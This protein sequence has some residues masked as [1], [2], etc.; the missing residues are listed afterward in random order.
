MPTSRREFL[1]WSSAYTAGFLGVQRL[2]AGD[3]IS[4]G[5]APNRGAGIGYGPLASDP[6]G[7]LDLP[8]G[9]RYQVISRTGDEMADGLLVPGKPDGMATFPGPDGLTLILRNHEN[10]P[11]DVGPFG[12]KNQRLSRIDK[13]LLYD[14]GEEK[15]PGYG[16]VS[17]VVYDT[18]QQ[19]VVK[20]FLS[21]GG[22]IRNCAGGPTPWGSW[23]TCEETTARKGDGVL[24]QYT[25][26]Q[27]HGYA[28]E[29]KAGAQ[30]GLQK[31]TPLRDMGRFYREAVAV[32][33]VT[34]IVYQTEDL[35]D[36]LLYRFVPKQ[37]GNLA[38]GGRLQALAVR[39]KKSLDTRNYDRQRV[40]VGDRLS[41]AWIDMHDVDAP[42][43][44][45]R[46]Q[47]FNAG[48]ARFGR[49]EGMW[50]SDGQIYFA[51]TEGGKKNIGQI[52]R[53]EPSAEGDTLEL[54]AEPND[55]RMVQNAD[56][57]TMSPWGD[58]VVCEDRQ[59]TTVRLVGVTPRGEFYT[60]ADN[61]AK[62]EFAG[63]C[64]SP[65][66]STLFVNIQPKGLTLAIT[67]PWHSATV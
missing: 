35:K 67:G 4:A 47:G 49:G 30:P 19:K 9:F 13:A 2:I 59:G 63:A 8:V 28:F 24:R 50:F 54:F 32:D 25:C 66:G 1:Q 17:T 48:A 14:R 52:W 56:N 12:D 11:T 64:F 39:D 18:K 42:T 60:L 3:V 62:G 27:D 53:L 16:G 6:E 21:L 65:D 34:G 43:D 23:I 58:L 57:L 5:P 10:E 41:A 44:E 45:L 38:A 20:Q 51:C 46:Y 36:G 37:P 31:A 33:P 22:T 7:L 55:N 61:N 15:W 26:E 29:V 40:A